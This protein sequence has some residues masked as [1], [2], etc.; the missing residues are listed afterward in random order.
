MTKMVKLT[1]KS[2]KKKLSL[3]NKRIINIIRTNNV[4]ENIKNIIKKNEVYYTIDDNELNIY[5]SGDILY[6]IQFTK[7]NL[8]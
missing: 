2:D 6:Q 8:N 4:P 7:V 5:R 3:N 1:V